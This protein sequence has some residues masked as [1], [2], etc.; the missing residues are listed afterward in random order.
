MEETL[1]KLPSGQQLELNFFSR[2]NTKVLQDFFP[3][4]DL[5]P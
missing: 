2:L 3:K 1:S 4:C 5:F